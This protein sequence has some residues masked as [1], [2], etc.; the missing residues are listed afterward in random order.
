MKHCPGV[1]HRL[2][3]AVRAEGG[4]G[5]AGR[6][7]SGRDSKQDMTGRVLVQCKGGCDAGYLKS[8]SKYINGE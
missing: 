6:V 1:A 8:N 2:E 4:G 5:A 7:R 3:G